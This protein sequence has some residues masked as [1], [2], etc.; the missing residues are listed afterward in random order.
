MRHCEKLDAL[1][2]FLKLT[3]YVM[4]IVYCNIS[5][6]LGFAQLVKL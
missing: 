2:W 6:T 5:Q 4:I 3:E 1:S